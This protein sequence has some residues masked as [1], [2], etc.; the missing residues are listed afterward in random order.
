VTNQRTSI[1][2]TYRKNR[3]QRPNRSL[4][5]SPARVFGFPALNAYP[6]ERLTTTYSSV[7]TVVSGL[8]AVW[9]VGATV[10]V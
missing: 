2:K 4:S 3:S 9:E 5:Y 8:A 1:L 10:A 7:E 6:A